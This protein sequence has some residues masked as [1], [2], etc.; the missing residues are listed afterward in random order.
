MTL[1]KGLKVLTQVK[2]IKDSIADFTAGNLQAFKAAF[3]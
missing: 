3:V 1:S 2:E